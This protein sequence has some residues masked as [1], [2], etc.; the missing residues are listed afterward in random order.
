MAGDV[1]EPLWRAMIGVVKFSVEG[2]ELA[3]HA[4]QGVLQPAGQCLGLLLLVVLVFALIDFPLQKFLHAQRMRMSLEEVKQEHKQNE[5]DPQMKGRRRRR[6]RELAHRIS[7][8]AV[9]RADLVVMNP[10]HYAVA[11]KYLDKEM[12]APRV[13]AKGADLVALRIRAMAEENKIPILEA[14][15]LTRAL[16]RHTQLGQEIPVAL[17]AA[18]AEVLTATRA[19]LGPRPSEAT[20]G[21]GPVDLRRPDA[22]RRQIM[23]LC[24][25]VHDDDAPAAAGV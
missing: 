15:P 10:T 21:D 18:V 16:Y 13:I 20:D 5:G 25:D 3:H 8:G 19:A 23:P 24:G 7:I 9:P 22:G 12:R 4:V 2:A 1:P 17:Y 11:L 6:Q 14:P